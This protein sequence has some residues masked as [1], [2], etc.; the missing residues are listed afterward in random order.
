MI[1]DK[2]QDIYIAETPVH[3][4]GWNIVDIIEG[5]DGEGRVILLVKNKKLGYRFVHCQLSAIPLRI[6]ENDDDEK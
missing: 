2:A 5:D 1:Y 3:L 4:I 6:L